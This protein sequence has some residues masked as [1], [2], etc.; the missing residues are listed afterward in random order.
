MPLL[1]TD[2]LA[3]CWLALSPRGTSTGVQ[4]RRAHHAWRPADW[5][6]AVFSL[7]SGQAVLSSCLLA[8]HATTL[9]CTIPETAAE[10]CRLL[11]SAGCA[12]HP[13]A[14]M[15]C[16]HMMQDLSEEPEG[17]HLSGPGRRLWG[18]AHGPARSCAAW[19]HSMPHLSRPDL[20]LT[21]LPFTE[22]R[23]GHQLRATICSTAHPL[24]T[25]TPR[26]SAGHVQ[27]GQHAGRLRGPCAGVRHEAVAVT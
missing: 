1:F 11:A 13:L 19:D 6:T 18:P 24:H 7:A 21:Q 16:K 9:C 4:T 26:P 25:S 15:A 17:L 12:T 8:W 2:C 10:G 20:R 27:S 23:A 5:E 22:A 3:S 14:T